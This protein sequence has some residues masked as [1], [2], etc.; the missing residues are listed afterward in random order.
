MP[1]MSIVQGL[2]QDTELP[3]IPVAKKGQVFSPDRLAHH[4]LQSAEELAHKTQEWVFVSSAHSVI[5]QRMKIG[6]QS[7][8]RLA[9]L[10]M[11]SL[12]ILSR[13]AWIESPSIDR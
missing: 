3:R 10:L 1:F 4:D 8:D 5:S 7:H 12:Y 9:P 13:S 2:A 6:T 11:E